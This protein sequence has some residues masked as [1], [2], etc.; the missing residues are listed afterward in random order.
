MIP[1]IYSDK[2]FNKKKII[3]I[4]VC[5]YIFIYI[6]VCKYMSDWLYLPFKRQSIYLESFRFNTF[7]TFIQ[8]I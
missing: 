5:E 1:T 3:Y 8:E 6:Y 2:L 7:G 4:Y